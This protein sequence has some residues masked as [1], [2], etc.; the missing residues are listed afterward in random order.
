MRRQRAAFARGRGSRGQQNCATELAP[1][2]YD[3][4]AEAEG[5]RPRWTLDPRI[6]LV[7]SLLFGAEQNRRLLIAFL[8][9]VL[10]PTTPI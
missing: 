10:R 8:N 9:D 6:D 5:L 3:F 4:M 1:A 7:F 2:R